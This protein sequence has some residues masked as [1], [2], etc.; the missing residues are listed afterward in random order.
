MSFWPSVLSR[1]SFSISMSIHFWNRRN[2][3]YIQNQMSGSSNCT[4]LSLLCCI[5]SLS[6][7]IYSSIPTPHR[8]AHVRVH[9]CAHLPVHVHRFDHI[10]VCVSTCIAFTHTRWER[11]HELLW[12]NFKNLFLWTLLFTD[13]VSQ[14]CERREHSIIILYR[15]SIQ[16]L[17]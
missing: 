12:H 5:L 1:Y 14:I 17:C 8:Y 9:A 11:F 7:L 4:I 3:C 6:H 10:C 2:P 15:Y 16:F 13:K